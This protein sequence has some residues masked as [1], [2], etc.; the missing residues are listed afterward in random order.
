MTGNSKKSKDTM[1]YKRIEE[2][3]ILCKQGDKEAILELIDTYKNLIS[4][5]S[6]SYFIK[7]YDDE[8]LLQIAKIAI[9]K[10]TE[11]YDITKG[12]NFTGF[13]EIFLRNTFTTLINKKENTVFTTSINKM[14][15]EDD[16]MARE[17]AEAL[18]S[19]ENLEEDFIHQE[20]IAAL[21][22]AL[23]KLTKEERELLLAAHSGYGGVKEYA[24]KSGK[25]YAKCR[26]RWN[27]A[28]EKIKNLMPD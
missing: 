13:L 24:K 7:G 10:A 19:D 15:F 14:V 5:C 3:V 23:D 28:F 20:Q 16:T 11:K 26:Y 6:T 21:R 1:S 4:K 17:Y 12:A 8:D 18:I 9:I 22:K 27:K 25:S 2:L